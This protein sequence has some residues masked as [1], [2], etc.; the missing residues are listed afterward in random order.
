M[1]PKDKVII[2]SS[3]GPFSYGFRLN[4]CIGYLNSYYNFTP[5]LPKYCKK[6]DDSK[7]NHL[8]DYCQRTI[9]SSTAS[10]KEPNYNDLLLDNECRNFMRDKLNYP[11]CVSDNM[12]YYD[13]YK[14]EWR[15]FLGSTSKIWADHDTLILRDPSGFVVDSYKY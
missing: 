10:C 1:T 8:S 4:S 13:F 2:Y 3:K 15:L 7:I 12:A 9:K 11:S 5:A 14:N 6:L